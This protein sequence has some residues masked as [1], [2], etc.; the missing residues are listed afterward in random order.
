VG[1][2]VLAAGDRLEHDTSI[3]L[4][5]KRELLAVQKA[6]ISTVQLIG[7]IPVEKSD[8]WGNSSIKQVIDELAVVVNSGLVDR[9]VTTT[10]R[11][12]SRPADGESVGLGA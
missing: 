7:N 6:A 11:D 5:I 12:N 9:V 10:E 8:K 1:D 3:T 4:V 2:P